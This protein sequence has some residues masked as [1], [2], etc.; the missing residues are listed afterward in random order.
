MLLEGLKSPL[1]L[2]IAQQDALWRG[3]FLF[4]LVK[5]LYDFTKIARNLTPTKENCPTSY[6]LCRQILV[7]WVKI[8]YDSNE[9]S[10]T[11]IPTNEKWPT[12]RPFRFRFWYFLV[13]CIV[14]LW[15]LKSEPNRENFQQ[16]PHGAD[17]S[18]F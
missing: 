1:H 7:L 11:L 5:I 13:N 16:F 3:I 12:F 6:P 9:R 10:W 15:Y 18:S 8:L 14:L 17:F 2:K 4:F